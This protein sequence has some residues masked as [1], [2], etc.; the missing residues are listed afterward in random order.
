MA[1]WSRG[2]GA[3]VVVVGVVVVVVVAG[4]VVVEPEAIVS[5]PTV[6]VVAWENGVEKGSSTTVVTVM[7]ILAVTVGPTDD[8][9][10]EPGK[11]G[12]YGS[13]INGGTVVVDC[14]AVDV[15]VTGVVVLVLAAGDE[16]DEVT[17]ARPGRAGTSATRATVSTPRPRRYSAVI[18]MTTREY[19]RARSFRSSNQPVRASGRGC[20][21]DAPFTSTLKNAADEPCDHRLATTNHDVP[22]GK[23]AR[24]TD[25]FVAARTVS[26]PAKI[27]WRCPSRR[28]WR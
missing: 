8:V 5:T 15:V 7:G 17:W 1:T 4:S 2:A 14:T 11:T 6:V 28:S 18:F 27:G 23:S 21:A 20:W 3:A 26:V 9:S 22:I 24:I 13:T 16:V 25:G 19:R 12:S 10:G